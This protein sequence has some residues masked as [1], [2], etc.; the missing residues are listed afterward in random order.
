MYGR[1]DVDVRARYVAAFPYDVGGRT[2][3]GKLKDLASAG[4]VEKA[5]VA[6]EPIVHEHLGKIQA[7]GIATVRDDT[8]YASHVVKPAYLAVAAAVSGATKLIP[9]FEERFSG[10]MH[11]LRDELLVF[12]SDSVRLVEDYQLRLRALLTSKLMG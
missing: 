1:L 2:M 7:L 3:F 8:S 12:D 10:I 11:A 9:Q 6:L 5:V 4:V